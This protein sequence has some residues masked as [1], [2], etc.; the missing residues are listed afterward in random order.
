MVRCEGLPDTAGVHS[1]SVRD[2]QLGALVAYTAVALLVVPFAVA[3]LVA[4]V[5][6]RAA[7]SRLQA[8]LPAVEQI[9][10][11]DMLTRPG[12]LEWHRPRWGAEG[13]R[14]PHYFICA[15][16]EMKQ[17]RI[18]IWLSAPLEAV[19]RL[20]TSRGAGGLRMDMLQMQLPQPR[21]I[22]EQEQLNSELVRSLLVSA[23]LR[24]EL[25]AG[26][27]GPAARSASGGRLARR[28]GLLYV[29]HFNGGP[30]RRT[31]YLYCNG[32]YS[33]PGR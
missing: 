15:G 21:T 9:I 31:L 25:V 14:R 30:D 8:A 1:G 5:P 10:R 27:A 29:V 4:A 2:H 6:A 18:S 12:P 11:D 26:Y 22:S 32:T 13:Y 33:P 16:G 24:P 19:K 17:P 20:D 7:C 28:H 23:G 3:Y